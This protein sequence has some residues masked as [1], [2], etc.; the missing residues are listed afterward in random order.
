MTVG[1]LCRFF[2]CSRVQ[3]CGFCNLLNKG[4]LFSVVGAIGAREDPCDVDVK[5]LEMTVELKGDELLTRRTRDGRLEED[6]L[7]EKDEPTNANENED[8]EEK[9]YTPPLS[10]NAAENLGAEIQSAETPKRIPGR[11]PTLFA[12]RLKACGQSTSQDREEV[13]EQSE[14][15]TDEALLCSEES[16]HPAE[17]KE[18]LEETQL[19]CADFEPLPRPSLDSEVRD[20]DQTEGGSAVSTPESRKGPESSST[21]KA[22]GEQFCETLNSALLL[23]SSDTLESL[24]SDNIFRAHQTLTELMNKVGS[25][26]RSK[27]RSPKQ[28]WTASPSC[29][30]N[31]GGITERCQCSGVMHSRGRFFVCKAHT[32]RP[33][34]RAHYQ[35]SH[36]SLVLFF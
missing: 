35:F 30:Q 29:E 2:A 19:E 10:T 7:S 33:I 9:S 27:S 32:Y 12:S 18:G 24:S 8:Q 36:F 3:S 25:A 4:F 1:L 26:L 22:S 23:A 6:Q 14:R 20:E 17:A 31:G 16:S 11:Q 28:C 34:F 13:R 15:P 5:Q 21:S